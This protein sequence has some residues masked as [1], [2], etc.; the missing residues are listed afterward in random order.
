MSASLLADEPIFRLSL[1]AYHQLAEAGAFDEGRVELLHGVVVRMSPQGPPHASVIVK[2]TRLFARH[3]PDTVELR[4]QLPLEAS[5]YD[6]PEPDLALCAAR[7]DPAASHPRTADLVVEVSDATRR[8]DLVTKPPI[9]ARAG[10]REYWVVDLGRRVVHVHA[11]PAGDLFEL[12]RVVRP[13]DTLTPAAFP[14]LHVAVAELFPV[15]SP[16]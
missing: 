10:V 9:Y 8:R 16:A 7:E 1:R 2:L 5:D 6:A 4:V 12:V 3:L 15:A 11:Q 13:G 14:D